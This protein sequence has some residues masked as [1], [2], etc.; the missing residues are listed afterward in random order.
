MVTT[1]EAVH[2]AV[3]ELADTY[4]LQLQQERDTATNARLALQASEDARETLQGT[5]EALQARYDA[6]RAQ[7]E[8]V[9]TVIALSDFAQQKAGLFAPSGVVG[10][11]RALTKYQIPPMTSTRAAEVAAVV[12][13][14]TILQTLMRVGGLSATQTVTRPRVADLT[15][16]G[17]KQG[18][19]YGGLAVGWSTGAVIERVTVYG[20]PGSSN[21]PP[22]ETHSLNLWHADGASLVDVILDGRDDTGAQV[23]ASMLMVNNSAGVTYTR[24]TAS[25][26]RYGFGLAMWRCS[27]VHELT[28]CDLR[29][30]RKAIN[31]EQSLAATY[32]FRG[33]DFRGTPAGYV[34]QVSTRDQASA[35]VEFHDPVVDAWPLKVRTYSPAAN[36]GLNGQRD[37]DIR[38]FIA[39]KDVTADPARFQI[40]KS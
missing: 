38:L 19:D 25:R 9:A 6:L 23:A 31:I 1:R 11:G 14:N 30:N 34:A 22:S 32:R 2:A 18:H 29:A 39:G 26:A 33:C 37:S 3:D 10:K 12:A 13:P 17:T 8:P 20:I 7:H 35:V 16:A 21:G 27:G 4:A 36:G 40:V 15:L 28:D 24:V 5:L